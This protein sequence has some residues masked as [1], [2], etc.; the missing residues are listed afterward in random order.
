MSTYPIQ[1]SETYISKHPKGLIKIKVN[2]TNNISHINALQ[3]EQKTKQNKSLLRYKNYQGNDG[4][5]KYTSSLLPSWRLLLSL[6]LSY[7]IIKKMLTNRIVMDRF[8]L[9]FNKIINIFSFL[10][11][12]RTTYAQISHNGQNS[13]SRSGCEILLYLNEYKLSH[14]H[15]K[16]KNKHILDKKTNEYLLYTTRLQNV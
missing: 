8:S 10:V 16:R 14:P 5:N 11:D 7:L 6:Y 1:L 15:H 2:K 4:R 3:F 9:F 12:K 13:L